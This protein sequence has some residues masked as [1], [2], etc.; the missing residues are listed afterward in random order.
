MISSEKWPPHEFE[1][2]RDSMETK[3]ISRYE[4]YCFL[5]VNFDELGALKQRAVECK[6]NENR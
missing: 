6:P 4:Q 5:E 1:K 2:M 3:H